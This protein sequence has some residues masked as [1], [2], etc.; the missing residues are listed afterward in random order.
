VSDRTITTDDGVSLHTRSDGHGDGPPLLLLNSLGTDL[1]MWDLQV[2]GWAATRRVVRFDQRGH[3][4]SQ[5]P[6]PPYSLDRLGQ[7]ALAVLDAYE[8]GTF[9]LCGL[10]LGGLVA[11]WLTGSAPERVRRAVFADTA[12]RVGTEEGWRARAETVR[13][14]GM[15]AVTDLV[16]DRFFSPAFRAA[17]SPAVAAV[18]RML[19]EASVDGYAG[20]CD[21]LARADLTE[22]AR[23]VRAPSLVVVGM[24]DEATP[25]ADARTLHG[26]LEDAELV[27]IPDAGH[28]ANLERPEFFGLVVHGF[29]TR[30]PGSKSETGPDQE[31]NCA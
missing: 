22:L 20:S 5:T 10:S 23:A 17:G 12:A 25:P 3:G 31:H 29:L 13:I 18:E 27:E 4:R 14:H 11:L 6:P 7:D 9:D 30:P 2:P 21:A 16:L 26:L 19:R 24:A 15:D 8:L 28:L 1:S